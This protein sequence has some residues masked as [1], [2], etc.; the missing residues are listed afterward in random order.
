MHVASFVVCIVGK[1]AQGGSRDGV[2]VLW[3]D[4]HLVFALY[5]LTL[6]RCVNINES[7][8]RVYS[9]YMALTKVK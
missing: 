5:H 2:K 9:I 4:F 8:K 3:C 6:R 7:T 1:M